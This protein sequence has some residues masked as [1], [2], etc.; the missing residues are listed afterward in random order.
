MTSIV[1]KIRSILLRHEIKDVKPIAA[2]A[3]NAL[4]IVIFEL[5]DVK[6]RYILLAQVVATILFALMFAVIETHETIARTIKANVLKSIQKLF[7]E[8]HG[9]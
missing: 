8:E 7:K 6:S 4:I 2:I 1:N 9:S 3:L 5:C